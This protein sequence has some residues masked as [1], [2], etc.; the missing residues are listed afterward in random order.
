MEFDFRTLRAS[1]RYRLLAGFVV[2]RPVAL[3]TTRAL[4][5]HENAVSKS[6][7]RGDAAIRVLQD[8]SVD[9]GAREFFTPI[10][11]LG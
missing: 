7:G 5:G 4:S 2:P 10:G 6:F 11:R 1:D 9:I 3:V 8:V